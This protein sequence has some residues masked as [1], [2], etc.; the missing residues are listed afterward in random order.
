[1]LLGDPAQLRAL[2][3]PMR[4]RILTETIEEP[5]TVKQ[6]AQSLGVPATRLYY[7]IKILQ[8]HR[9]LRI[10]SR[11]MVGSIQERSYLATARN[12]NPDPSLTASALD[13]SG[14]LGAMTDLLQAEL[15]LAARGDSAAPVG[16]PQSSLPILAFSEL[17]LND[18]EM[19]VIAR[20]LEELLLAYGPQAGRERGGRRRLRLFLAAYSLSPSRATDAP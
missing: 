15:E 6:L 19:E 17:W 11:R 14:V 16:E 12:W 10:A 20:R 2:A 3:D 4:I 9:M 13:V 18:E 7:H 1:M 5:R 8:R